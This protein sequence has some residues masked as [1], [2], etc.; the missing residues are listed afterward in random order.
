MSC[1]LC[2]Q[3]GGELLWSDDR[4]RVVLINHDDC[5]GFCRVIWS[6]HVKE[7][8]DLSA[9]D[10]M[11]LMTVVFTVERVI[12]TVLAPDKINLASLGNQTPHLHWHVI[13]RWTTDRFFPSPIWAPPMR[14]TYLQPDVAR[15]FDDLRSTIV[16]ALFSLDDK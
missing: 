11:H 3:I 7:M 14:E 4:L 12:R 2:E 13:P 15:K 6:G 16:Q 9:F 5:P 1:E 8:T 10:Q